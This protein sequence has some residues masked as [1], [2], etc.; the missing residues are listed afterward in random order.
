M[1][2]TN[3]S[4]NKT[5]AEYTNPTDDEILLDN[6]ASKRTLESLYNTLEQDE[7]DIDVESLKEKIADVCGKVMQLYCPMI[8]N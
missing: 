1:H 7:R 2:L 6:Q 4:I 5:N 3:Y 8:E